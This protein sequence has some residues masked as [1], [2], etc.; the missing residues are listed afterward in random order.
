[1]KRSAPHPSSSRLAAVGLAIVTALPI[2]VGWPY[3][4]ALT[5]LMCALYGGGRLLARVAVEVAEY[6]NLIRTNAHVHRQ[7]RIL[8]TYRDNFAIKVRAEFP[9]WRGGLYLP[10][11]ERRQRPE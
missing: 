2:L 5:A 6:R 3:T 1:M 11:Y 4:V 9:S 7:S 10:V 8:N